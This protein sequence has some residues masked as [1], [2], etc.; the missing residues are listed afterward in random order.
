MNLTRPL[1]EWQ[2]DAYAK[3]IENGRRGIAAVVTGAGKTVFALHCLREYR[4]TVPAATAV[5]VVPTDALLDQWVE[6]TVTFLGIPL[7]SLVI[8]NSRSRITLSKLHIGVINT[9]AQLATRVEAPPSLLIVDECHKAASPVF[10]QIFRLP[11]EAS[12][13]LSATPERQYDDGLVSTLIPSLGPIL[14]NYTYKD[15]LRDKI[16]V[17]FSLHNIVFDF[18]T[19]ETERYSKLTK[20]IQAAINKYGVDAQETIRL[21]LARSRMS[22]ACPSRV[23]IALKI[24]ARHKDKKI[25]IFHEDI[26]A[27]EAIHTAL[28]HFQIPSGV[29]HSGMTLAKRVE[30]L[31]AY[32]KGEIRVLVSCRALDEGFNVP[33]TEI[34]IIAASTATHR[35]RV[36]RLGRVLRPSSNKSHAHIYSIVAAPTEIRRLAKEAEDLEEIAEVT[37]NKA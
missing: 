20:G 16:I 30:T 36:Q 6:E 4:R 2:K 24:V 31:A 29:Y 27:C 33:E 15:A 9:V 28:S 8:L 35:Q 10:Q 17:P 21:L 3:W 1:R 13:G 22:N 5:I 25:L 7:R 14:C 34:G 12:L 26:A 32:R 19:E 18:S 37:W 11:T 23:N